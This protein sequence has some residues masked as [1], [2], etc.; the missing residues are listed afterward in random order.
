MSTEFNLRA[1]RE[2]ARA[3]LKAFFAKQGREDIHI[4]FYNGTSREGI[5]KHYRKLQRKTDV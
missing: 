1:W 3:K 2:K 5:L 4:G